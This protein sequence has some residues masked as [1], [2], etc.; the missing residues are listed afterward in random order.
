MDKEKNLWR[1]FTQTGCTEAYLQ[2]KRCADTGP[3]GPKRE[4]GSIIQYENILA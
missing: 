1:V 4:R 2:Y 3:K